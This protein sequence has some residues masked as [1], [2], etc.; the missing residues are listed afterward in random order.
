MIQS[1]LLLKKLTLVSVRRV[2]GKKPVKRHEGPLR[3][4]MGDVEA[5]AWMKAV[6]LDRK[7][8]TQGQQREDLVTGQMW[9]RRG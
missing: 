1:S 8:E 5:G 6:R 9:A 2:D 3:V 4:Y 7:E